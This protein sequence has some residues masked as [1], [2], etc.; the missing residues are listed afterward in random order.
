VKR[1]LAVDNYQ[2]FIEKEQLCN[3]TPLE[4]PHN[5]NCKISWNEYLFHAKLVSVLIPLVGQQPGPQQKHRTFMS[6]FSDA[7]LDP[8]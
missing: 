6:F 4:L 8:F 1:T 5:C 3:Y 2:Q 7:A